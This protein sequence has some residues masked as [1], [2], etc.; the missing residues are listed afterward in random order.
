MAAPE[1][2]QIIG[3]C[4]SPKLTVEIENRTHCLQLLKGFHFG[5]ISIDEVR[6]WH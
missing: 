5:H 4:S 3:T 6:P 2:I 1:E